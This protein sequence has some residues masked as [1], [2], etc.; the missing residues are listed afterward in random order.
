MTL[1]DLAGRDTNHYPTAP[2]NIK[3]KFNRILL[4]HPG[5]I[6]DLVWAL[7]TAREI[8]REFAEDGKVDIATSPYCKGIIPLLEI[9]PW[10]RSAFVLPEW[11]VVF[12]AP[13]A[14][15]IPPPYFSSNGKVLDLK[16]KVAGPEW[17]L[18]LHLGMREWPG[19]T[20]YEYY[21]NL[22]QREYGLRVNL[23][24]RTPWLSVQ[25]YAGE[26]KQ[27]S[28]CWSD[29]WV[30]LKVGLIAAISKAF[31]NEVFRLL[32]SPD[33]RLNKEFR[34]PITN[35]LV[36]PCDILTCAEQIKFSKFLITCN[37]SP[38]PLANAL[39]VRAVIIEP[40]SPRHQE[41]FKHKAGR[42]TYLDGFDAR[43]C[44]ELIR[45]ML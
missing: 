36:E 34:F 21:P 27:I 41:V 5:K 25:E 45:K 24:P 11:N 33:S 6:G 23:L 28:M 3:K 44:V 30:E 12:S 16:P 10:I 32:P 19:P 38:H 8:A 9:Q 2:I 7:A 29:E 17:D 15:V 4:T 35:F 14:P 39:G 13:V 43:E 37:S 26:P 22:V 20:L 31:P 40:S 42:N 1:E 18:V